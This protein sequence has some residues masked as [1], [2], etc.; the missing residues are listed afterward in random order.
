V[1]KVNVGAITFIII[2]SF[3]NLSILP[4]SISNNEYNKSKTIINIYLENP[5]NIGFSMTVILGVI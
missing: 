4:I 5:E 1:K 3:S 2:S